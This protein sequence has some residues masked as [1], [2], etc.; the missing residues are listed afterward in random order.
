M[1]DAVYIHTPNPNYDYFPHKINKLERHCNLPNTFKDLIDLEQ[2]DVAYYKSEY[3]KV[4]F[5]YISTAKLN[6]AINK[7]NQT[8]RNK[9]SALPAEYV[10]S[11]SKLAMCQCEASY[12]LSNEQTIRCGR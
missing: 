8:T 7:R 10:D 1:S 6:R 3:E 11:I 2:F 12:N 4:Y 9:S 5:I